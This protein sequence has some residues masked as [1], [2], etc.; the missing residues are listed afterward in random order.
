MK[1]G[2]IEG[3]IL[4]G[5]TCFTGSWSGALP[6]SQASLGLSGWRPEA[7]PVRTLPILQALRGWLDTHYAPPDPDR[8]PPCLSPCPELPLVAIVG[9]DNITAPFLQPVTLQCVGTGMPTPSL[10]WWKDGV[11][12]AALGG[13]LQVRLGAPGLVGQLGAGGGALFRDPGDPVRAPGSLGTG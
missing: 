7:S 13:K 9:G 3:R 6:L 4:K 8:D 11:A 5:K 10:R 1:G 2:C 12:L